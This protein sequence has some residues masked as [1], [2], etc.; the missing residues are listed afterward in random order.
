MT[1][2]E[3][4]D[5][6]VVHRLCGALPSPHGVVDATGK[7]IASSFASSRLIVGVGAAANPQDVDLY[8]FHFSRVQLFNDCVSAAFC[9]TMQ[10]LLGKRLGR[11]LTEGEILSLAYSYAGAQHLYAPGNFPDT[12]SSCALT[13]KWWRDHGIVLE[14]DC[15]ETSDNITSVPS[16]D[17]WQRGAG[18]TVRGCY[19]LTDGAQAPDEL[20]AVLNLAEQGINTSSNVVVIADQK[21][22]Q[23]GLDGIY[24]SPGGA[25]LGG[26]S[27]PIVGYSSKK[28]PTGAFKIGDSWGQ[29]WWWMTREYVASYCHE[30]YLMEAAPAGAVT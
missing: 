5:Y 13:L 27:L 24:D 20:C 21:M 3:G 14:R 17:L 7:P 25:V 19:Q 11:P 9:A 10:I 8:P 15:P 1:G 22:A 2:R 12:G 29:G 18:A 30:M 16:D 26:H 6:P 4:V 28:G 23:V